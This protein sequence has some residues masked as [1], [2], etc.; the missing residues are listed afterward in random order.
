MRHDSCELY[1]ASG[2]AKIFSLAL[3]PVHW[4]DPGR[5]QNDRFYNFLNVITGTINIPATSLFAVG[6]GCYRN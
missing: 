2:S 1:I 4:Q 5:T 3:L 6:L